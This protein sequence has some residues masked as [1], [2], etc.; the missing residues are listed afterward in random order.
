MQAFHFEPR[1]ARFL[2]IR[3]EEASRFVARTVDRVQRLDLERD[4]R[5]A[6]TLLAQANSTARLLAEAPDAARLGELFQEYIQKLERAEQ[7]I[8]GL[9]QRVVGQ[10]PETAQEPTEEPTP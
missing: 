5:Y 1:V 8:L 7:A 10:G 3:L 4:A 2:T 6:G 9:H